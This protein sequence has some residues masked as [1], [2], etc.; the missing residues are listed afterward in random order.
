VAMR[1]Q[2]VSYGVETCG[3]RLGVSADHTPAVPD[4]IAR[5]CARPD[6]PIARTPLDH[7]PWLLMAPLRL[8]VWDFLQGPLTP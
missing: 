3:R 6:T 1:G 7:F 2:R 8:P 4:P 5:T